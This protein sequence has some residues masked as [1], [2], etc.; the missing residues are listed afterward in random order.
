MVGALSDQLW[1]E[2]S[3][4]AVYLLNRTPRYAH[5]WK[6]PYEKFFGTPPAC[7]YL[8]VYRCKVFALT[9]N[10]MLKRFRMKHLKPR[11]WIEYLVG[12]ASTN[13]Y[14]I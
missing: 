11:T 12:Y 10:A 7:H 13:Q 3:S 5:G 9:A 14:R 8:R 4:A 1:P 6:T 2:V